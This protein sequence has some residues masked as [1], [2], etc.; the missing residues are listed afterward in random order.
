MATLHW[1]EHACF[2]LTTDDQ[3]R[4]MFDPWLDENR[5]QTLPS[6]MSRDSTSSR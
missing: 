5:F 2:T 1:H 6:T 3:T 4:I